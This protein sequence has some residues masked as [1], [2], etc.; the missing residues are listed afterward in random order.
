MWLDMSCRCNLQRLVTILTKV[1]KL[2]VRA[3]KMKILLH[4]AFLFV[5][6]IDWEKQ[7]NNSIFLIACDIRDR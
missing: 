5:Q 1:E 4:P 7:K 3:P 6:N 2:K